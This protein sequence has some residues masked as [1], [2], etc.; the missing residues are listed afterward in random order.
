M[1]IVVNFKTQEI[2]GTGKTLEN[3]QEI[4]KAIG[5][6]DISLRPYLFIRKG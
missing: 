5:N 4:K 3:A 6:T 2:Y 1:Y